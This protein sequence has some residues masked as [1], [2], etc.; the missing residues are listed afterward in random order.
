MPLDFLKSLWQTAC[1]KEYELIVKNFQALFTFRAAGFA[2]V[3]RPTMTALMRNLFHLRLSVFPD[4]HRA[5]VSVR[6]LDALRNGRR[7]KTSDSTGCFMRFLFVFVL[8]VANVRTFPPWLQRA[9][10]SAHQAA[11]IHRTFGTVQFRGIGFVATE[12]LEKVVDQ[13]TKTMMNAAR[14]ATAAEQIVGKLK[15]IIVFFLIILGI[16]LKIICK[17]T[18]EIPVMML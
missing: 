14:T 2:Q 16:G 8:G 6:H 1:K 10:Q 12:A 5:F 7:K 3:P 11:G 15:V 18:Y 4:F 9:E 13:L 17:L